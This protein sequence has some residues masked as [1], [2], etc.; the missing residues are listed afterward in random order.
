M[1]YADI[2]D[3]FE[4]EVYDK[5][6][7]ELST[8]FEDSDKEDIIDAVVKKASEIDKRDTSAIEPNWKK[9]LEKKGDTS[10]D[11][12]ISNNLDKG[13]KELQS[14]T[15]LNLQQETRVAK[16]LDEVAKDIGV[17]ITKEELKLLGTRKISNVA[18]VLDLPEEAVQQIVIDLGGELVGKEATSFRL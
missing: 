1:T 11:N 3:Y 2:I 13:I 8:Y 4:D 17:D 18:R 10:I 6:E 14:I 7:D 16:R 9:A 12:I 5:A 15:G